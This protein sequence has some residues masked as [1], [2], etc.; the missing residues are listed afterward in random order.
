MKVNLN[1][2]NDNNPMGY[3]ENEF[4]QI[5]P[6]RNWGDIISYYLIRELSGDKNFTFT[7]IVCATPAYW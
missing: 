4:I 6:V 3:H 2:R 5:D 1:H 7:P